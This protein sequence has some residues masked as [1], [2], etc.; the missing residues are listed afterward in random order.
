M[1]PI[2]A[3]EDRS[4]P[5]N[6]NLKNAAVVRDTLLCAALSSNVAVGAFDA[7]S[8]SSTWRAP[9][10]VG[11]V[12]IHPSS[13]LCSKRDLARTRPLL[14][15]HTLNVTTQPFIRDV[16]VVS[17]VALM[18]FSDFTIRHQDSRATL[19]RSGDVTVIVDAQTAVLV[20]AL[21]GAVQREVTRRVAHPNAAV[22]TELQQ[23][24]ARII[25]ESESSRRLY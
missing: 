4:S 2:L 14:V 25:Q 16:S 3:A 6:V 13:T 7:T 17:P 12:V 24:V 1:Q 10:P 22:S 8:G 11:R 23:A 19:L 21:K 15:Y 18:L 9:Q 5:L 20:K